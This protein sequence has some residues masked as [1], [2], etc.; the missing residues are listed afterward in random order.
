M[1]YLPPVGS[2]NPSDAPI[3]PAVVKASISIEEASKTA[4]HPI[5]THTSKTTPVPKPSKAVAQNLA[6]LPPSHQKS[7]QTM[8]IVETPDSRIPT[9]EIHSQPLRAA[10]VANLA[11]A[12]R[13]KQAGVGP[14]RIASQIIQKAGKQQPPIDLNKICLE[15]TRNLVNYQNEKKYFG[16]KVVLSFIFGLFFGGLYYAIEKSKDIEEAGRKVDQSISELTEAISSI[17]K[18]D[19]VLRLPIASNIKLGNLRGDLVKAL[20]GQEVDMGTFELIANPSKPFFSLSAV[21]SKPIPPTIFRNKLALAIDRQDRL[22]KLRDMCMAFFFVPIVSFIFGYEAER[23]RSSIEQQIK[24]TKDQ[25]KVEKEKV[26]Y[27]LKN[28]DGILSNKDKLKSVV[29]YLYKEYKDDEIIYF[30]GYSEFDHDANAQKEFPS[31]E[32]K[33]H[34]LINNISDN[35]LTPTQK[36]DIK[37]RLEALKKE[38]ED[39]ER[40]FSSTS[41]P[42]TEGKLLE[43]FNQKL[44]AAKKRVKDKEEAT[45]KLNPAAAL[46]IEK[47]EIAVLTSLMNEVRRHGA[48]TPSEREKDLEKGPKIGGDETSEWDD[49]YDKFLKLRNEAVKRYKELDGN[50]PNLMIRLSAQTEV[51]QRI[52]LSKTLPNPAAPTSKPITAP[53]PIPVAGPLPKI[54]TAVPTVPTPVAPT[55]VEEEPSALSYPATNAAMPTPPPAF[56]P[57]P[58]SPLPEV[59]PAAPASASQSSQPV[60]SSMQ[61]P[62]LSEGSATPI[63]PPVSPPIQSAV[64]PPVPPPPPAFPPTPPPPPLYPPAPPPPPP[65]EPSVDA[66]ASLAPL[67]Q[68]LQPEVPPPVLPL[69]LSPEPFVAVAAPLVVPSPQPP[70]ITEERAEEIMSEKYPEVW[71]RDIPGMDPTMKGIADKII[72]KSKLINKGNAQSIVSEM[73]KGLEI[74]INLK[75]D[76]EE[77]YKKLP[78]VFAELEQCLQIKENQLRK[79]I[80]SAHKMEK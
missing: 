24:A 45:I 42:E 77:G 58:P 80:E 73:E 59:A 64:P 27:S 54:P 43:N 51:Q 10:M 29:E 22:M 53:F 50:M 76:L 56:P 20:A 6:S 21:P 44:E 3:I 60:L 38:Y 40:I 79:I 57:P 78:D 11:N 5:S 55:S 66:E 68:S 16:A 28:L 4:S 18:E 62:R 46:R 61:Q 36:N 35:K 19:N 70:E 17:E 52:A 9:E 8:K 67:S 48:V 15:A 41:V 14:K 47:E 1:V 71:S 39:T 37:I 12:S 31:G 2:S 49:L 23:S 30:P 33:K 32:I 34:K 75:N 63:P 25:I 69:P 74:F 26:E 65:P 72:E 7:S 13:V